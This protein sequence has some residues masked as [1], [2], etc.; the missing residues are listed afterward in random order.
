MGGRGLSP[1]YRAKLMMLRMHYPKTTYIASGKAA[2][3]TQWSCK[4]S[5]L[6]STSQTLKVLH[7]SVYD[8]LNHAAYQ[9][10]VGVALRQSARG[11]H[12]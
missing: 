11:L 4:S 7:R 6:T 1:G 5:Q 3:R 8:S 9:P 10:G 12:A 2:L